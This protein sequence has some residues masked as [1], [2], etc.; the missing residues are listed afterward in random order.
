MRM[1]R[2]LIPTS[3]RLRIIGDLLFLFL[4]I[5][6]GKVAGNDLSEGC[7][8]HITFSYGYQLCSH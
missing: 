5:E 1:S 6:L 4:E 2:L 3:V 7:E 8:Q